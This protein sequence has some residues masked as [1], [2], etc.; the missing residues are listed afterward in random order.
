MSMSNVLILG[1][2]GHIGKLVADE[3]VDSGHRVRL[4]VRSRN[5]ID[6][7]IDREVFEGDAHDENDLYRAMEG[8]D[9]VFSN[10]GSY[11]MKSFATAVVSAMKQRGIR[12]LLW[13]A[14]ADIYKEFSTLT[15][16]KKTMSRLAVRPVSREAIFTI[17]VK[18]LI[19]SRTAAWTTR[20]SVGIG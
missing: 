15:G 17:N 10:L 8:I 4:F 20:F 5:K 18:E 12:R 1:A 2:S 13:T 16:L 7:P 11:G 9:I 3:L 19:T 14:T 6:A